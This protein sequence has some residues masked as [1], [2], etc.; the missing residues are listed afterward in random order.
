MC[1]RQIRSLHLPS[2]VV[3]HDVRICDERPFRRQAAHASSAQRVSTIK[4]M[5]AS[6]AKGNARTLQPTQRTDAFTSSEDH[7]EDHRP[8]LRRSV[9]AHSRR[10]SI[11]TPPRSHTPRLVLE[12]H[13]LHPVVCRKSWGLEELTRSCV[14]RQ[15]TD[16][17]SS[18]VWWIN[19]RPGRQG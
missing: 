17:Q 1:R 6:K 7:A 16:T 13:S 3:V 8:P 12:H 5:K 2:H 14:I 4:R 10:S 9:T 18:Q 19:T 11:N 15:R